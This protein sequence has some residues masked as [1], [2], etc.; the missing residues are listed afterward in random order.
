M[1]GR[2]IYLEFLFPIKDYLSSLKIKE[3]FFDGVFPAGIA[4][5]LHHILIR[6]LS[7]DKINQF[8]TQLISLL[9]ILIG[10]TITSVTILVASSSK[11]IEALKKTSAK[12]FINRKEISLYK[13]IL[14][15]MT[16][17]LLGELFSLALTIVFYLMTLKNGNS[18][19]IR[20][21]FSIIIFLIIHIIL[22]N[23]R[24]V[25]NFYF[26]FWNEDI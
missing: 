16:F 18:N 9:A 6:Y 21:I 12:R 10:F 2:I 25:T 14:G 1:I 8:S 3:A 5:I 11:S 7:F 22:L 24:N 26:T 17:V 13:L 4:V 15:N 19:S 23:L 20:I